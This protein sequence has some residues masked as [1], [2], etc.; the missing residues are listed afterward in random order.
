M[1]SKYMP[2]EKELFHV[3]TYRCGHASDE[4]DYE[5]VEAAIKLGIERIVFTDHAPFPGNPFLSRMKYEQLPEYISTI[6]E[7]KDKYN[8]QIEILCGLE[9]EFLP[10][11]LEYYKQLREMDGIDI[12]IVGQ[13]FYEKEP[14]VFSYSDTD[15]TYEYKGQCEA[16]AQAVRS[17]IFDVIAHPDRSFRA[18]DKLGEGETKAAKELIDAVL[19]C[20]INN[21]PYLEK[22]ISSIKTAKFYKE[23][24]WELCPE[25]IKT[26]V[27]LDAHSV[28][29]LT[30]YWRFIVRNKGKL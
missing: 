29:E 6:N 3:H 7:L 10:S 18:C 13:H 4:M 24:F 22:N 11:Y 30:D 8:D 26:T 25:E 17:R 2:I 28:D 20:E 9:V 15:K 19:S 14:G 23:D 21:R 1:K 5:Y 16:M 27:G 12:L